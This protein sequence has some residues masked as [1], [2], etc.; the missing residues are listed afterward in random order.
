MQNLVQDSFLA[1]RGI[2]ESVYFVFLKKLRIKLS[3]DEERLN[4]EEGRVN[5][6]KN[7]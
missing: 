6:L 4:K 5:R 2:A 3:Q 1:S 7:F